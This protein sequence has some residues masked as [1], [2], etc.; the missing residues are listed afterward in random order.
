[1]FDEFITKKGEYEYNCSNTCLFD[2]NGLNNYQGHHYLIL[3]VIAKIS[4]LA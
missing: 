2:E 3:E 4:S 1:M